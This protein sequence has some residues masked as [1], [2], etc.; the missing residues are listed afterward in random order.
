VLLKSD[1]FKYLKCQLEYRRIDYEA[2]DNGISRPRRDR[3]SRFS[4]FG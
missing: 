2:L 3:F 1:L 4:V